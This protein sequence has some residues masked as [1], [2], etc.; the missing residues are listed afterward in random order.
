ML[1]T[2]LKSMLEIEYIVNEPSKILVK[3]SNGYFSGYTE[4]YINIKRLTTLANELEGFPKTLD[5]EV[6]FISLP[7]STEDSNLT[8][9]IYCRNNKGHTSVLFGIRS[10]QKFDMPIEYATFEI[11][12]EV[13]ALDTFIQSLANSSLKGQGLARLLGISSINE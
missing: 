1:G 8:L 9:K 13:S 12:F 6:S 2:K 5:S 11:Q 7:S 10:E 3:A 4:D